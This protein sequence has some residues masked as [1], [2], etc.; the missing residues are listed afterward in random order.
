MEQQ[1]HRL[2][3]GLAL[4]LFEVMKRLKVFTTQGSVSLFETLEIEK[5]VRNGALC[6]W[7]AKTHCGHLVLCDG[8]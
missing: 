3:Y 7:F 2:D 5:G 8:T 4:V 1:E 6:A